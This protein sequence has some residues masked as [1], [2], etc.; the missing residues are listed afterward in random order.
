MHSMPERNQIFGH[1]LPKC[2]HFEAHFLMKMKILRAGLLASH[3]HIAV[4]AMKKELKL[5]GEVA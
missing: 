3:S 4:F 1:Q 5:W 2:C